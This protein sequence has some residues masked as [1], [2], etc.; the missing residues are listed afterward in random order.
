MAPTPAGQN[1]PI[2]IKR[3]KKG[4][5]AAHHGGAWKVAYADFVTAMMAF[6][7]LLWLLNVTTAEQRRGIADYF[8]PA[9]VARSTSGSGGVLGGLTITVP[10]AMISP[11]SPI[12]IDTPMQTRP[13]EDSPKPSKSE[14]ENDFPQSGK[15]E[16]Q[17]PDER[18]V[19]EAL[20]RQEAQQF[21]EAE[22]KL[23]E[24]IGGI[25]EL[26]HLAKNLVID[27][28]PEGLRIQIVDEANYSMFPL[29]RSDM[30]P[31]TRQLMEQ[32]AKVVGS[33]P[34]R[35]SITGHTDSTPFA[36]GGGTYGNWELSTDRANASRRAL[37]QAGIPEDRI[38]TVVGR[39]D[40][41]HLVADQPNSPRNRRI[42]IVLLRE[43]PPSLPLP[44]AG[45]AAAAPPKGPAASPAP[46]PAPVPGRAPATTSPAPRG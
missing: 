37:I 4:G 14:E 9:S 17:S 3:K 31:Q 35:L 12:A 29:G 10:G 40:R 46:A 16:R 45:P 28:T 6:F 27:Q 24:T 1:Q 2:I 39:A 36:T 30:F 21:A 7:L 13:G 34:N 42:G 11:G 26:A 44:A 15:A 33:L 43:R 38:S 41:D 19:A 8:S 20:A 5:H 25:P 22:R 18:Q 32:V 23:F